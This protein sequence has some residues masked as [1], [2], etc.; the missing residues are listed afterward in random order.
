MFQRP[1]IG[2]V[3]FDIRYIILLQSVKPLKVYAYNRFWLRFANIEFDLTDLDVYEKHFTVMNYIPTH[4]KQ[5]Y[6]QDFIKAFEEQYPGFDWPEVE[7]SIF[8]MIKGVF[9]GATALPPPAGIGHCAQAGAM[10]ATDLMLTW[11][12][13][14][15]QE[16]GDNKGR[17]IPQMLEFN[18]MPDCERACQY[19]PEFFNNVFN[20]LFLDKTEGQ[21]VTL[22]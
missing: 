5:M 22:L 21:N 2:K 12:D 19:Y 15:K 20:T 10:Y 14:N 13:E 17:M 9:E 4:L 8:K 1:E 18:W 11:S 3:K 16:N 6:C 7:A